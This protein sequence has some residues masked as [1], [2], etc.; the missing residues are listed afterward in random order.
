MPARTA[1]DKTA[2]KLPSTSIAV[3]PSG[4]T[5]DSSAATCS[6]LPIA[7][8][9]HRLTMHCQWGWLSISIFSFFFVLGDLDLWPLTLILEFGQ[10]FCTVHPAAKVQ[11]P[12]FNCSKV[13]VLTNKLTTKQTPLKTSTSL[14][15]A[16]PVG[17][18]IIYHITSYRILSYHIISNS[19]YKM[20]CI[21]LYWAFNMTKNA[22]HVKIPTAIWNIRYR[23]INLMGTIKG[24]L[25][26]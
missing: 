6:V 24:R 25:N 14:R 26:K 5:M 12:M 16:T 1:S 15:Y 19:I 4:H 13:I 7:H 21:G 20:Q 3:T 18:H 9:T 2:G 23:W 17:N 22:M 11:R 10:N 8:C